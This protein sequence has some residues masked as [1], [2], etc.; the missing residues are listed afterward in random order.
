V[1]EPKRKKDSFGGCTVER[2]S[3]DVKPGTSLTPKALNIVL[4][5]EEALKLQLSIGQCLGRLNEYNRSTTEGRRSALLLT[6]Y[7]D[8]KR[9]VVLESKLAKPKP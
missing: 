3:P 1:A 9:V 4:P 8:A 7:L 2:F 6:V 5:F